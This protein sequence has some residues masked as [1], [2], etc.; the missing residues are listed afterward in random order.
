MDRA[1]IMHTM[2]IA[3][4]DSSGR[5]V[6]YVEDGVH[7][8]LFT[9]EPVGHI[10]GQA[11]YAFTGT[12][13]GYF[14]NGWVRDHSGACVLFTADATGDAPVKPIQHTR[15]LKWEKRDKPVKGPI[16]PRPT[17]PSESPSWS[18]LSPEEFFSQ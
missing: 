17:K 16:A 4:Y 11:I 15:P 2:D 6:A 12:H 10:I 1:D 7:I 3:L 8:Y 18:S 5:P 9:G 13:L 14:E